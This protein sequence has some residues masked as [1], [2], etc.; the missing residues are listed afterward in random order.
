MH[1]PEERDPFQNAPIGPRYYPYVDPNPDKDRDTAL[2]GFY[3]LCMMGLVLSLFQLLVRAPFG[4]VA[5]LIFGYIAIV[6]RQRHN[7]R[8]GNKYLYYMIFAAIMA[9]LCTSIYIYMTM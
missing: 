3:C 1:A 2:V 4:D 6:C 8:N 9:V 5:A 7:V